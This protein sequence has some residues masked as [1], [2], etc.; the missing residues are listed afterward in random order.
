MTQANILWRRVDT[1]GH[2]ACRLEPCDGGW[3]LSG[4]ASFGEDGVIYSLR[5]DVRHDADWVTQRAQVTGWAGARALDIAI[6]RDADG[7]W[8]MNGVDIAGL[9]SAM[10]VDLGFTPATN[11]SAIRRLTLDV[12]Q[13]GG[14]V[15]AWLD[16]SDWVL[17]PLEQYY[18][19]RAE[20]EYEYG[21]PAHS[22]RA[23]LQVAANGLVLDYPEIWRAVSPVPD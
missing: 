19:R 2:D 13:R 4:T 9:E 23:D 6:H 5:Y 8:Q 20:R 1:E 21:S 16:M 17:K 15:A 10:D 14:G 7:S 11:T 3:R 18:E 22:Y 12:G